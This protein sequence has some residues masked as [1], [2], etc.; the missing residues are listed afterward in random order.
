MSIFPAS[1]L[2][3]VGSNEEGITE[4]PLYKEVKWNFDKGIP[5][6]KGGD[7]V[8]CEGIEAIKV[9]AYKAL[10][11]ER[12]KH[13]IY[14]DGYGNEMKSLIGASFYRDFTI[15]RIKKYVWDALMINPYIIAINSVEVN[16]SGDLILVDLVM[17]TIYGEVNLSV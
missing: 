5:L 7:V 2:D 11:T 8:L 6:F 15:S 9:W 10:L 17:N 1:V 16:F 12:Y 3:V 14:N 13:I 4:L